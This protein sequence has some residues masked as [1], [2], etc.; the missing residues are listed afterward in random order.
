M[1]LHMITCAYFPMKAGNAQVGRQLVLKYR[2]KAYVFKY[3]GILFGYIPAN[4]ERKCRQV[5]GTYK[6]LT[7]KVP[8]VIA[9]RCGLSVERELRYPKN[10][11]KAIRIAYTEIL[12]KIEQWKETPHLSSDGKRITSVKQLFRN[13]VLVAGIANKPSKYENLAETVEEM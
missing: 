1:Q 6:I 11:Q 9:L 3:M 10:A 2:T 5:D 7:K 12:N 8:D 13:G 4:T